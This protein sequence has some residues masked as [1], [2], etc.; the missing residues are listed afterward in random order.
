MN[1]Q[2]KTL[3]YQRIFNP[4][5]CRI[6]IATCLSALCLI[7]L[8][9]QAAMITVTSANDGGPGSLR[10]ALADANDG[11]TINFEAYIHSIIL[12]YGELVVNKSVTISGP[13]PHT[14]F[15]VNANNLSRVFHITNGVTVSMSGMWI[16]FGQAWGGGGAILNDHSTLTVSNCTINGNIGSDLG[17]GI[18]NDGSFGSAHLEINNSSVFGN[19]S[20]VG[21]GGIYNN[22]WSGSAT[23]TINNST[24]SFNL[25][26]S[27]GGGIYNDGIQGSATLTINNSILHNNASVYEGSRGGAI[28]NEGCGTA[29]VTISN[30]VLSA[31]STSYLGGA[32]YSAGTNGGSETLEINNSTLSGN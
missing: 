28:G 18:C 15:E 31:N 7:A 30:S 24:V 13:D 22:G 5:I 21:G 26:G 14:Y 27:A 6:L 23:L 25:A 1:A 17:G 12:V 8:G 2:M 3:M 9:T 20:D 29:T 19:S 16:V 10:Q 4:S 11:D 32:I